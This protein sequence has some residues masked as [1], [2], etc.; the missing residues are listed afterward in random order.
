M[1]KIFRNYFYVGIIAVEISRAGPTT[2]VI[3]SR[4]LDIRWA[5]AANTTV[6]KSGLNGLDQYWESPTTTSQ[7]TVEKKFL[8]DFLE[9]P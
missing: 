8:A 3:F 6:G 9:S 5:F 2:T 1:P 7:V 4:I